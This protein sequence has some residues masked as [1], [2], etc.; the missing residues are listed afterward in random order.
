[1]VW[2]GVVGSKRCI[3]GNH[4]NQGG[5][6]MGGGEK[7]EGRGGGAACPCLS[8][9]SRLLMKPTRCGRGFN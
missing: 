6:V 4:R 8:L 9:S 1:M 5:V 2:C 3:P 7:D